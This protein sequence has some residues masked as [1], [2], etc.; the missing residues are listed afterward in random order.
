MGTA[1]AAYPDL[2]ILFTPGYAKNAIVHA[3]RLD[4]GVELLT[5]VEREQ[6]SFLPDPRFEHASAVAP[7]EHCREAFRS[8]AKLLLD[9]EKNGWRGKDWTCDPCD[10]KAGELSIFPGNSPF[11]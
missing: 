5:W 10:V 6:R 7:A 1:K 2:Q 9:K 3:G 4:T 11:S 8:S